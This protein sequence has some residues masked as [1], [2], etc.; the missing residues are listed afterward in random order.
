MKVNVKNIQNSEPFNWSVFYNIL[1]FF[2]F[3][4]FFFWNGTKLKSAV[5]CDT[6]LLADLRSVMAAAT[7]HG[8][9]RTLA[10]LQPIPARAEGKTLFRFHDWWRH[11]AGVGE[12]QNSP[13]GASTPAQCSHDLETV[14]GKL[15]TALYRL[16]RHACSRPCAFYC[17][18]L[19]LTI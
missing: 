7:P 16:F 9:W 1:A 6:K 11:W 19:P 15:C 13:T 4:F 3:F 18:L 8:G 2:F 10:P 5:V 17:T 12:T 14:S